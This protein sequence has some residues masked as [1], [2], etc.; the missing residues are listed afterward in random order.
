D[1]AGNN[2]TRNQTPTV[3]YDTSEPTAGIQ[4][5]THGGF[6]SALATISGTSVDNVGVS[7]IALSI[8]DI[9]A[10][11]PNCYAYTSNAFNAACPNFF[12]A[13]GVVGAWTF[14]GITWTGNHQYIVTSRATDQ[15][16]NEQSTFNPSTSSNTF[17][18]ATGTEAPVVAITNPTADRHKDLLSGGLSTIAGTAAI[19]A[20]NVISRVLVRIRESEGLFYYWNPGSLTFDGVASAEVAWTTATYTSNWTSWTLSS[21][22]PYV[23]G[24]K[25]DIEARA[26]DMA[27]NFSVTFTTVVVYDATA[28]E[29]AVGF[30]AN[31]SFINA[32]SMTTGTLVDK[33]GSGANLGKVPDVQVQFKR[34][35]GA[36]SCWTGVAWAGCPQTLIPPNLIKVWQ[37]SWTINTGNLPTPM[38]SG[39]SY[40]ITSSG[41]DN[42]APTGNVEGFGSVRGST[43]IYNADPPVSSIAAPLSGA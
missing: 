39:T 7:T 4:V 11:A 9:S 37:T 20:P 36:G 33:T 1:Y 41:T 5:P 26:R 13:Q 27:G 22:V 40:Y 30:P 28:P 6:Y 43:F 2:W 31:N 12:P 19:N 32:L 38:T 8:Q 29:T 24:S 21:G 35:S 17:T 10:A 42:A 15:A 23:D 18:Y 34:L 25:Y 3:T 14:T 16:T